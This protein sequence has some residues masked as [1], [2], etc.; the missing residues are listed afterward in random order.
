LNALPAGSE[1]VNQKV[2]IYRFDSSKLVGVFHAVSSVFDDDGEKK[3]PPVL[4][5]GAMNCLA[6]SFWDGFGS[7]DESIENADALELAA[8]LKNAG[9]T[10]Q[11]AWTVREAS[12]AC[13]AEL[14]SKCDADVLRQHN[15]VST[16]VECASHALKDRKFWKVR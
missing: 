4:V 12:A 5:A 10:K 14:A 8:I 9:G 3:E 1:S 7:K 15:F 2:E 13:T 6:A 11:P 16:M